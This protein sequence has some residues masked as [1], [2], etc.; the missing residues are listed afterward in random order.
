T[1][2]LVEDTPF[3]N[4]SRGVIRKNVRIMVRCAP[5]TPVV[6][7]N[8][9]RRKTSH[10]RGAALEKKGEP[11]LRDFFRDIRKSSCTREV[12]SLSVWCLLGWQHRKSHS[13][14]CPLFH[15]FPSP[16][17]PLS[18]LQ[19]DALTVTE[20]R[21][22]VK[23][24]SLLLSRGALSSRSSAGLSRRSSAVRTQRS[25]PLPD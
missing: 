24:E 23:M 18:T 13:S 22:E 15:P 25:E 6:L 9:G 12:P 3:N 21:L 16:S 2:R 11:E 19:R 8:C 5:W 14:G 7:G 10:R 1:L 20:A 4:S 17:V